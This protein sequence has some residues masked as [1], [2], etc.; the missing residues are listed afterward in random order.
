MK[1]FKSFDKAI[2]YYKQQG[3]TQE[4]NI[5]FDTITDIETKKQF[6]TFDF[7]IE[8]NEEILE[9]EGFIQVFLVST[10]NGSKGF[11]VNTYGPYS[12]PVSID[13]ID[14]LNLKNISKLD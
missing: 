10:N 9:D 14:K 11:L 7:E 6:D 13:M 3:F 12:D 4:F 1:N 2:A 5:S 8:S